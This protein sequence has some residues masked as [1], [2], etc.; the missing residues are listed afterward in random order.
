ML[1]LHLVKTH[2]HDGLDCLL[3]ALPGE[4]VIYTHHLSNLILH[5]VSDNKRCPIVILLWHG[6]NLLFLEVRS[7]LFGHLGKHLP[8]QLDRVLGTIPERHKLD[9]VSLCI[10]V[11]CL[12]VQRS[13]IGVKLHHFIE[14]GVTNANNNNRESKTTRS[15]DLIYSFL[16]IVDNPISNNQNN[17]ILLIVLTLLHAHLV[18]KSVHI[19]QNFAEMSWAIQLHLLE[20]LIVGI[21]HPLHCV[22][23]W[24]EDVSVQSE[25]VGSRVV[26]GSW[27]LCP[28][29]IHWVHLVGVV[30]LD[31]AQH[32]LDRGSVF[33]YKILRVQEVEG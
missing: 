18:Y 26:G 29:T 1:H 5:F 25:A 10:L 4:C 13:H 17:G 8:G 24:L 22:A 31:D 3:S 7:K 11:E 16:H 30:V 20:R 12:G 28:E 19:L 32:T 6:L 21:E 15:D 9:N 27:Q 23:L 14:I 2:A 33:V